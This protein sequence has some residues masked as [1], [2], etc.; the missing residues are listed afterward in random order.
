[1]TMAGIVMAQV[2][3]GLALADEP[4]LARGVGLLSNRLLLV[5]I[6]FELGDDRAARLHARSGT[7]S[8]T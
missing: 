3:A 8:S 2:G 6:A 5:G 7:T 4:P 1:M